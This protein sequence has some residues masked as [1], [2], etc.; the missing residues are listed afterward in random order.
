MSSIAPRLLNV[1]V[2]FTLLAGCGLSKPG[3]SSYLG[4]WEGTVDG[5]GASGIRCVVAASKLAE[6]IVIK[7]ENAG[8]NVGACRDVYD[9]IFTL[10]PE[11]SLTKSGPMGMNTTVQ[12]N[13]ADGTLAVSYYRGLTS[14]AKLP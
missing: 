9:G 12:F 1:C 2:L 13:K 8:A 14:L 7:T 4:R 10:T 5:V 11:G 6:S 3:A